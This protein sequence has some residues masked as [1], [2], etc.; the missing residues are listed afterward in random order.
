MCKLFQGVLS[1]ENGDVLARHHNRV[2]SEFIESVL[3][4]MDLTDLER[5]IVGAAIRMEV[6]ERLVP[7]LY[8]VAALLLD[9]DAGVLGQCLPAWL[10]RVSS[11]MPGQSTFLSEMG[12]L[13]DPSGADLVDENL[14][15]QL[16]ESEVRKAFKGHLWEMAPCVSRGATSLA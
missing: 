13:L 14:G 4:E 11:V 2:I 10:D 3:A 5:N 6:E 12:R 9:A 16:G 1:V 7:G 15:L 8:A